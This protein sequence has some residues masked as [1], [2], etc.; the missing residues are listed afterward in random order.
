[1][2][3]NTMAVPIL[4]GL[5]VRTTTAALI[6]YSAHYGMTRLYTYFCIP[7]G[8]HG[9]LQGLITTASPICATLLSIISHSH[10]TY[11][12][13]IVTSL[14]K[15]LVDSISGVGKLPGP[16]PDIGGTGGG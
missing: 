11:S 7:D 6:S 9:F 10:I 14:A 12:T 13:L 16:I 1:V 2:Y 8:F 4:A 15:I 5:I 3:T